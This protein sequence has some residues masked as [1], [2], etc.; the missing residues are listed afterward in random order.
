MTA[1]TLDRIMKMISHWM[2]TRANNYIGSRYGS[3]PL[4][5]LHQ[6]LDTLSADA[7]IAKLK[8]DIPILAQLGDAVNIYQQEVGNDKKR[9]FIEF[10]GQMAE[11]IT[12]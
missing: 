8:E 4:S 11:V 1:V 12:L 5:L 2:A 3:D 9:I 7:Y 10:N 6:P